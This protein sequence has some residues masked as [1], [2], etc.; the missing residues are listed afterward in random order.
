M[1]ESWGSLRWIASRRLMTFVTMAWVGIFA[2]ITPSLEGGVGDHYQEG[3]GNFSRIQTQGASLPSHPSSYQAGPT[4]SLPTPSGPTPS[5]A[6]PS[7]PTPSGHETPMPPLNHPDSSA[8]GAPLELSSSN[9]AEAPS[10]PRGF[11]L[12]MTRLG[13]ALGCFTVFLDQVMKVRAQS[14][15]TNVEC[16]A[17]GDGV[18]AETKE[19]LKTQSGNQNKFYECLDKPS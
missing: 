1:R 10:N 8:S 19:I 13:N 15:D 6:G 14:V 2:V 12:Y 11:S 9:A 18:C 17:R 16:S 4:A 5:K 7:I 3:G